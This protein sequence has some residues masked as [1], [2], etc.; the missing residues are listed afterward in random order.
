ML[1]KKVIKIKNKHLSQLLKELDDERRAAELGIQFL[2]KAMKSVGDKLWEVIKKE[3]PK[4]SSDS[5]IRTNY[6]QEDN[7]IIY[8]IQEG[9]NEHTRTRRAKRKNRQS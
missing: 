6:S 8:Y 1:V 9:K 2:T 7:V 3:Y 5:H 4:L